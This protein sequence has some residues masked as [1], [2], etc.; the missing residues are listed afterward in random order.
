MPGAESSA[1]LPEAA[2]EVI[3]SVFLLRKAPRHAVQACTPPPPNILPLA[4]R[5]YSSLSLTASAGL[6]LLAPHSLVTGCL[7]F[8]LL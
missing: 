2:T 6:L 8:Q 7:G 1:S 5:F 3:L 4:P